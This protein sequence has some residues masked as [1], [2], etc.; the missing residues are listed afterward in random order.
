MLPSQPEFQPNQPQNL[1]QPFSLADDVL[2][3]ICMGESSKF[4][5]S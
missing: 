4:K 2:H 5:K 3:E 1:M